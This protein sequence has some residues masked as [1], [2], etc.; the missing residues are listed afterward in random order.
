MFSCFLGFQTEN[1]DPFAH[2]CSV[3]SF[4]GQLLLQNGREEGMGKRETGVCGQET[5]QPGRDPGRRAVHASSSLPSVLPAE[6]LVPQGQRA[7][8][9][10]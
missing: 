10:G 7:V 8:A 3:F 1:T 4:P 6:P 2:Y 9:S 5:P